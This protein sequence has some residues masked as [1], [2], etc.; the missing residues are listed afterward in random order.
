MWPFNRSKRP[1]YKYINTLIENMSKDYQN[2]RFRGGYLDKNSNT[3]CYY[4]V[5]NWATTWCITVGN[6]DVYKYVAGLSDRIEICDWDAVLLIL[7]K[8]EKK[9]TEALSKL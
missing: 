5:G 6:F 8:I 3:I 9:R 4:Y 1:S 2:G 7:D